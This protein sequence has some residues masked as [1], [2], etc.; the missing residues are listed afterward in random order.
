M[1]ATSF[2]S[3]CVTNVCDKNWEGD[4]RKR[5]GEELF[6]RTSWLASVGPD[7]FPDIPVPALQHRVRSDN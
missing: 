7:G 4:G 2:A 5:S 6:S 3:T 1:K